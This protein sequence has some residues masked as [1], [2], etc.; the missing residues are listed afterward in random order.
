MDASQPHWWDHTRSAIAARILV[1]LGEECGVA[2]SAMLA[3]SGLR[4]IDLDDPETQI[5]AGQELAIARNLL[6][7][8]GDRPGL[9]ARAG[10]RYTLGSLGIWGFT[11]V[12][13]PTVR[14]LAKLGTRYAALSFA[15]IRPDY[16]ED[17]QYGRVVY[18]STDIPADVRGF[19]VERELAK[20]LALEPVIVGARP[21]FHVETSFGDE[22]AA[23][24]RR[25][26]P[27]REVRTG[28]PQDALV[29]NRSLLDDAMPQS[30]PVTAR[31]MEAQCARLLEQRRQRRGAAAEVRAK[32]L[33]QLQEPLAMDKI[34]H[35][36]DMEER[37]LRR[38]LT[39]EG[40]SF[41]ELADEVRS[42]IAVEL[43]A[44]GHLTVEEVAVR[45][46]Y[47]DASG[48]SRAFKRWT[49]QRPG[50]YHLA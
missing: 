15:F 14:D 38:K 40:T 12:T 7:R 18:D 28:H 42:T 16:I 25:L 5:E 24:L 45:L 17:A 29:F 9:G 19:F 41:R 35:Q 33:A 20:I 47:H 26:A 36:L 4:R 3:G 43:L 39:A 22:R 48:F 6:R 32:M 8:N 37:T 11:M 49:G 31:A 50:R 1:E 21:G 2:E 23:A 10:G 44:D 27:H 34:A 46:G 30:D 13:S